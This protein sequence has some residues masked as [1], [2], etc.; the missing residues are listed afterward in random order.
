MTLWSNSVCATGAYIGLLI[1][2]LFK[3][4]LYHQWHATTQSC[5][6][7]SHRIVYW[8]GP[9]AAG[10]FFI[11]SY[12][13]W[14]IFKIAFLIIIVTSH[15]SHIRPMLINYSNFSF[16]GPFIPM[17]HCLKKLEPCVWMIFRDTAFSDYHLTRVIRCNNMYRPIYIRA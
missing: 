3:F 12:T 16:I 2:A 14:D 1:T 7:S 11:I 4:A 10:N 15:N 17:F 13:S 9:T 8:V 6:L 5:R